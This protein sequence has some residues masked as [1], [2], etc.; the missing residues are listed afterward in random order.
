MD[1]RYC[2]PARL[3]R[4]MAFAAR[5]ADTLP[6][7]SLRYPRR[8]DVLDEVATAIRRTIAS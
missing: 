2:E 6:V 5:V 7:Y 3:A 8:F 4:Q 1:T